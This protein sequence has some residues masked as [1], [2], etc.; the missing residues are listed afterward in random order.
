MDKRN[1]IVF[2]QKIAGILMIAKNRLN[3]VKTDKDTP[4]KNVFAFKNNENFVD[5]LNKIIERKAEIVKAV[6]DILN[7]E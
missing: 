4:T 3:K 7:R 5:T 2:D 6:E 1:F